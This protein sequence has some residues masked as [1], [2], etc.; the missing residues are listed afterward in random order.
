MGSPGGP[1]EAWSID[2]QGNLHHPPGARALTRSEQ[3]GVLLTALLLL[4]LAI[5]RLEFTES[6]P[7]GALPQG[8]SLVDSLLRASAGALD[9]QARRSR[10]LEEGERLDPNRSEEW[11]LDRLPGVGPGLARSMV[12]SRT[13]EG[14]FQSVED[15]LRVRGIGPATLERIG[16]FLSLPSARGNSM[17]GRS[18]G[19]AGPGDAGRGSGRAPALVDLNRASASELESLPGIGPALARRIIAYRSEHGPFG[20]PG[21]LS[22]VRGIGPA[23]LERLAGR[24]R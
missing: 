17:G 7:D 10:P 4:G 15:L 22:K 13:E 18:A 8:A 3:L 9:D 11:E 20:S 19:A 5:L 12:R 16:P 6:L 21:D 23:L 2:S 24:V 14:P 1:R